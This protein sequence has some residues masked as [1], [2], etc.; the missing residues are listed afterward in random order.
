LPSG[1]LKHS[2]TLHASTSR[3]FSRFPYNLGELDI[4]IDAIFGDVRD[5]SPGRQSLKKQN[6]QHKAEG[7][8]IHQKQTVFSNSCS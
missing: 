2:A 8:K 5:K 3:V 7:G 1:R 4:D 6:P